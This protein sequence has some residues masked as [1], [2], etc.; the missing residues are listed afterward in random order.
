ME[1]NKLSF[2][3]EGHFDG[4]ATKQVALVG[5]YQECSG[6]KGRFIVILDQPRRGQPKVR[7]VDA[8]PTERQFGVLSV[9]NNGSIV[10][11]GC[12]ECDGSSVLEWDPKKR[13]FAWA[14]DSDDE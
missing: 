12:M 11:W 8:L 6:R 7:F 13:R 10:A 5:V 9:G 2:A 1:A 3:V 4:S 14:H